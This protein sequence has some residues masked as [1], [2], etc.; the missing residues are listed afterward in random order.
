MVKSRAASPTAIHTTD[1]FFP[2][3]F[4]DPF[5]HDPT[6]TGTDAERAAGERIE[7]VGRVVKKGGAPTDDDGNFSFITIMPGGYPLG[8]GQNAFFAD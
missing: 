1:P 3:D 5:D 8:S 7:V 4:F 6:T 2:A